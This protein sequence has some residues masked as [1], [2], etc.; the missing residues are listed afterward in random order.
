MNHAVPHFAKSPTPS[1]T[2]TMHVVQATNHDGNQY[3]L[4]HGGIP[5]TDN[6]VDKRPDEKSPKIEVMTPPSAHRREE[7]NTTSTAA[8]RCMHDN[9]E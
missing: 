7:M 8:K 9:T 5:T 1:A 2:T 3:K 4:N 6:K